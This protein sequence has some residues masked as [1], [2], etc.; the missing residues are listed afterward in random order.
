[1]GTLESADD[2]YK[3]VAANDFID[4]QLDLGGKEAAYVDADA[5]L[6]LASDVLLKASF[7]NN[8]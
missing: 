1:M 5:N 8:G 6:E 2:V 4:V 7:Y 3:E